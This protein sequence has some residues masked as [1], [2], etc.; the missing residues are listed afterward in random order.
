MWGSSRSTWQTL[1]AVTMTASPPEGTWRISVGLD[2]TSAVYQQA[3]GP[4][5]GCVLVL[6]HGASTDREHPTM[7][8]LASTF[9]DNG[10]S[11]VRFN[12]LYTEKKKGPPD[13]MPRLMECFTSAVE[14]VRWAV[15]QHR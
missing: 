3:E 6:G 9:L 15:V 14:H 8:R 5:A 2:E 12:F 7:Q 4:L 13:R 1:R 10:L 11:V